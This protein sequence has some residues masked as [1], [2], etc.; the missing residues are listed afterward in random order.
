MPTAT[1]VE[2]RK[3]LGKWELFIQCNGNSENSTFYQT[4]PS[5][6]SHL[7]GTE[8]I[9]IIHRATQ[10][11]CFNCT[12]RSNRRRTCAKRFQSNAIK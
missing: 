6:P 8:A 10:C 7:I 12:K 3:L 5:E 9:T 1:T 4:T 2:V 11:H